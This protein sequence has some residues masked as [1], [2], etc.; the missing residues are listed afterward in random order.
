MLKILATT[1][2]AT[3]L[4]TGMAFAQMGEAPWTM[5]EFMAV[6]PEVTPEV[7]AEIDTNG[8]GLI[9]EAEL[10]AAIEAGLI[11]PADD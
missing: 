10:E 1:L 2:A 6:Y 8:D 3:I 11:E 5:E 9:D 7:F 4:G